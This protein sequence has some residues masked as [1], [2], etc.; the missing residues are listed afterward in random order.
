MGKIFSSLI[1]LMFF[2]NISYSQNSNKSSPDTTHFILHDN[3]MR[4]VILLGEFYHTDFNATRDLNR[5]GIWTKTL[6]TLNYQNGYAF[7]SENVSKNMLA[8]LRLK[9]M[10]SQKF[11]LFREILG[12]AQMTAVGIMAYQHIKRYGFIKQA[13][14]MQK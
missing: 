5:A 14:N 10:D 8:P 9:Y 13:D 3:S 1:I 11:S 12:A 2:S 7:I 6:S 4:G